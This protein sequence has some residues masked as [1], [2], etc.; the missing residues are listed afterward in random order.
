MWGP[1]LGT[2]VV[3]SLAEAGAGYGLGEF[4][5]SGL[6]MMLVILFFPAGIVGIP[7]ALKRFVDRRRGIL[8]EE[9]DAGATTA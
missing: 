7:R 9:E 4:M 3:A 2:A 6:L 8:V 5:I 1:L